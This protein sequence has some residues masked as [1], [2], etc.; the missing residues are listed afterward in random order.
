MQYF[1]SFDRYNLLFKH[2][3][4]TMFILSILNSYYKPPSLLTIL[5]NHLAF[6]V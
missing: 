6:L 2:N 1:Y 5:Q 3:Y 4:S